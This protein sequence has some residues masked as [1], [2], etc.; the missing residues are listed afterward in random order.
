[1][2]FLECAIPRFVYCKS[3]SGF[4]AASPPS[5]VNCQ[6]GRSPFKRS[7]SYWLEVDQPATL[8]LPFINNHHHNHHLSLL[9][10]PPVPTVPLTVSLTAT[11]PCGLSLCP[12]Y[13]P[14][15]PG[16]RL[17]E[18]VP[19]RSGHPHTNYSFRRVL[20]VGVYP[21]LQRAMEIGVRHSGTEIVQLWWMDG[22]EGHFIADKVD[23]WRI[24]TSSN[25]LHNYDVTIFS[26]VTITTS[27]CFLFS[28]RF[29]SVAHL[30]IT[31]D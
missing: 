22:G 29:L 21:Y 9:S 8:H 23:C 5:S 6:A 18:A 31:K 4:R 19:S 7:D 30:A 1:M 14:R 28:F 16:L 13:W 27:F 3:A 2:S 24:N 11:H 25:S 12:H 10:C 15:A 20:A 17:P 26:S